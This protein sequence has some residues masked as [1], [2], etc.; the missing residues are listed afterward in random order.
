MR[1]IVAGTISYNV[2]EAVVALTAG[3]IASSAALV[4]FGL[5]S[6]VE[7]LS[8]VAVAWQ[9]AGRDPRARER[10]ALRLIAVSFLG[11]SAF[12]TV[13]AVRTLAGADEPAHS[14]VGIGLAVASLLIMPAFS[15]FER[16]T[17]RELGSASV[18]ADSRQT[19]L[20]AWL[21]GVLLVGLLL[22][23]TLGWAWADPVAALLIAAW[24]VHEGLEAWRGEAEHVPVSVMLTDDEDGD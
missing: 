22:N 11:L 6:V 8:A 18:V 24:A 12:V 20:C 7:V 1:W 19:L 3:G 13:D 21:S 16:R 4:G 9:F 5:D 15:W 17:G 10:T 23:A 2:V 14:P